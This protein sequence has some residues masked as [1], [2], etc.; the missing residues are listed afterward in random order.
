M[1]GDVVIGVQKREDE[2]HEPF[3]TVIH[4]LKHQRYQQDIDDTKLTAE[5]LKE[6]VKR[7][8]ALVK[9]RRGKDFPDSPWDQLMGRGRRGVR[10]VDE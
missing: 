9:E 1:Y 6:L 5:D 2:D 7:F 10:I 3:E 4:T 8:K